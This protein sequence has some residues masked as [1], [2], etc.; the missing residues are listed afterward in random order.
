MPQ[1][2]NDTTGELI[3]P[4]VSRA[5]T[6]W[7]RAIGYLGRRTVDAGEGLWFERC[8]AIHT[9]GLRAC[10]DIV[11]L[12]H[13]QTVVRIVSRARRNRIFD[14]GA[15]AAAV[16]ELGPGVAGQRVRIGDRLELEECEP[17]CACGPHSRP[18]FA[19]ND[20][21]VARKCALFR[22][23]RPRVQLPNVRLG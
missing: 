7:Q 3:A 8:S 21:R 4:C 1:L 17:E 13:E 5:T 14:G 6:P 9:L 19:D 22:K 16:L 2:R 15:G 11:F 10:I 12:D 23:V 20:K 18:P